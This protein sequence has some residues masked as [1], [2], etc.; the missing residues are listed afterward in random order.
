MDCMDRWV[1]CTE[2]ALEK[3]HSQ[4]DNIAT[5]S[6]GTACQ[7]MSYSHYSDEI[8]VQSVVLSMECL[9]NHDPLQTEVECQGICT[10]GRIKG[11]GCYN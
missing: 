7:I 2:A 1:Q 5:T 9:W 10:R 11:W 8:P 3:G 6:Q 4:A